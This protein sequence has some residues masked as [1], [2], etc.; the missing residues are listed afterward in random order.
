MSPD[1]FV[2]TVDA[3]RLSRVLEAFRDPS[4]TSLT[5]FLLGELQRAVLVEPRA[6]SQ[7]IVT[8]NSR[9]RFRLD[10]AREAREATLVCPGR[11][12]SLL[13]RISVLT[14]LGSAL[15]GMREGETIA[16]NGLDETLQRVPSGLYMVHLSVV[17]KV[18][19]VEETRTAPVVVT[20]RLS[21]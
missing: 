17:D 4:Y 14:P 12:D 13:G 3:A 9:V 19:G 1:I 11:E 21:R 15:I 10:G 16:W 2:T 18:T 6:V 8:M 5:K 20:T 7:S